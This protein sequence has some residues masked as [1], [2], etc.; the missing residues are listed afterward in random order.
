MLGQP[1]DQITLPAG[2]RFTDVLVRMR[3]SIDQALQDNSLGA[4]IAVVTHAGP[5]RI[6]LSHYLS[7][8]PW[9]HE[10]L[11]LDP[12]SVTVH[13]RLSVGMIHTCGLRHGQGVVVQSDV[14]RK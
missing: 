3:A 1:V 4:G 11:R 9:E 5:L 14:F 7:I 6:L 10:R 13:T 2:E 8:P 12:G